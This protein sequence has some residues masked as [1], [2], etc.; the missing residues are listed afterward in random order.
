MRKRVIEK[1]R[2]LNMKYEKNSKEKE[3]RKLQ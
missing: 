1:I 3:K 2:M